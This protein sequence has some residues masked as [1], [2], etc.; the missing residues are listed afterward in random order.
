MA[1][2]LDVDNIYQSQGGKIPLKWTA[3][4]VNKIKIS[5]TVLSLIFLLVGIKDLSHDESHL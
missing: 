2:D 3:P 5:Y 4:E 1:R